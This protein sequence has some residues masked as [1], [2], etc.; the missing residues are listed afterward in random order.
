M[1]QRQVTFVEAVKMALQQNYC[2]F[3]GRSSRSEYWWFVLFNF[4]LSAVISLV[5]SFS[6]TVELIMSG[7]VSLALL[8][9]GL[10]LAVRRLHDTGRSG[11]WLFLALIPIVGAVIL[12]IW[13]IQPS[14]EHP[15]QY[16]PEPNV[17]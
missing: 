7:V 4:I 11:W 6:Q 12:L 2:N 5:F 15:N 10:G 13:M 3:E 14:Q 16:G 17:M 1:N 9:P 8:L